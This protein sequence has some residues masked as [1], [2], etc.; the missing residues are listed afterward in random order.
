M[1][2]DRDRDE[3]RKSCNLKGAKAPEKYFHSLAANDGEIQRTEMVLNV[4]QEIK[5][6]G[7]L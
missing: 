1:Y 4:N 6:T 2:R 7:K 5:Q 3:G